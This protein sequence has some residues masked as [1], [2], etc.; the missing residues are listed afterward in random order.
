MILAR[1]RELADPHQPHPKTDGWKQTVFAY[2]NANPHTFRQNAILAIP[3]PV[4]AEFEPALMKA[5]EDPD[6][7]V[8]RSACE[9]AGKSGRTAFIRPL[10]RIVETTHE[11]FVQ[12]AASSSAQ[13][14][15]ARVELWEAWC[16]VITDQDFMSEALTQLA[17]GPLHLPS[18]SSSGNSN[19]T[20][21]QR[22]AIRNAWRKF[23]RNRLGRT[24]A[25]RRSHRI[26]CPDRF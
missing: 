10:C 12:S 11:T 25:H 8:L 5:L 17:L 7:G 13:A 16:E 15:G 20:R 24:A 9:V 6:W 4:P 21:E 18:K 2:I 23:V 3:T 1:F 14:L 19:F 26:P 22:F